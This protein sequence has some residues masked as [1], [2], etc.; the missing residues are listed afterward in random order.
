[1]QHAL[2]TLAIVAILLG[3]AAGASA[4]KTSSKST[5]TT[6]TV[7]STKECTAF[8]L[9][10]SGPQPVSA[11]L[12]EDGFTITLTNVG[13]RSCQI[14]GYPTVRFYTNAGRLLTFS[15]S[16]ASQ[17][18]HRRAPRLVTLA[19]RGHAYFLV[20]KYRCD[21]GNRYVSSFFYLFAPYTTASPTVKH[22]SGIGPGVMDYCKGSSRGPGQSLG[23]TPIVA[24][25]VQLFS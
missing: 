5:T 24:A 22:T 23:I 2:A 18:F 19:P 10:F 12:G 16:H 25:R 15:Y 9:A 4:A 13:T 17:Y 6:T 8:Q 3:P 21:L 20:A 14:H 11:Q 7:T 1:V